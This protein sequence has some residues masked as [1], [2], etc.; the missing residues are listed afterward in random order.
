MNKT[1]ARATV[2]LTLLA[3]YAC[4]G[5]PAATGVA[6]EARDAPESEAASGDS[7]PTA[8]VDPTPEAPTETPA[9][10]VRKGDVGFVSTGSM[11]TARQSHAA[12]VL[13]DGRV[14]VVGGRTAIGGRR[15]VRQKVYP[16]AEVYD[17]ASGSWS[18]AGSMA[19]ERSRHTVTLLEDGR[20]LAV[21]TKGKKTIPEVFDPSADAWSLTG[22]MTAPRGE[23]AATLLGDGTV[24]VT[25][26]RTATLQYLNE[27]EIY[28]PATDAW[29]EAASMADERAFHTATLLAS[30]KV[31][32]VGSDLT[33][34]FLVT[35]EL[36]DPETGSWS[37]TGSL[38]DGR[39]NHTAT[40]L[41]DGRV[42]VVGSKEKRSAEVYDP[43]TGSWSPAGSAAETR[44][45][46]A[47]AILPDG[48][49]LVLGGSFDPY[50]GQATSRSS[51][52]IYDPS[53]NTW[54]SAGNMSDGRFRFT[55]TT[56]PDG[57][58]LVVGGQH[59]QQI[60]DTAE[61]FSP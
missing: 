18:P 58:V 3:V 12:T 46:H 31:L 39:A 9:K 8:S 43:S 29:T 17:P 24:L 34:T 20:V 28:D 57:R 54:S 33:L 37:P 45:E 38:A 49:V 61:I 10:E 11:E 52:E 4:G 2:A 1:L 47:A 51:A 15:A 36:Y 21:G 55:A 40:L 30:G 22:E 35:A 6:E 23:H 5:S 19:N 16:S 50:S 25:G 44:G 53:S 42:L 48:R 41:Q 60:Y 14:L 7:V 59:E 56:L 27:A 26:G 13:A 32:A